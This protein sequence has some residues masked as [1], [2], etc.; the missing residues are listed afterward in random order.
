MLRFI[1]LLLV[2]FIIQN[3]FAQHHVNMW[4]RATFSIAATKKLNVDA[5]L[6]HRRQN[7]WGNQNPFSNN[8]TTS[9]RI[10]LYYKHNPN[11]QFGFSP[12]AIFNHQSII[13]KESDLRKPSV[14]EYR[15]A[16]AVDLQQKITAKL[17]AIYR[18]GAEWRI[19]EANPKHVLRIRNRFG[20]RYDVN[21]KLSLQLFEEVFLNANALHTLNAFDH[22]RVVFYTIYKP[23]PSVKIEMGYMFAS[24]P[25][26]DK[27]YYLHESNFLLNLTYTLPKAKHRMID[28]QAKQGAS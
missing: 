28:K 22:N 17:F 8:L 13:N 10:W 24:R 16:V 3:A 20:L 12:F 25:L 11:V 23:I 5:E 2:S 18:P 6:Q 4:F 14:R 21:Q 1:L 26:R 7:G 19:F 15:F 27:Q 9:G